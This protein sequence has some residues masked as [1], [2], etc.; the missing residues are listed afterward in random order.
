[1]EVTRIV[2]GE[3]A[4]NAYVV[5]GE[6]DGKCVLID[7]ADNADYLIAYLEEKD[8]E[9]EAIILTHGHY[10]HILAIPGLQSKWPSLEVYCHSLDVSKELYEYDM[11]RKYP[12]LQVIE[13]KKFVED[14]DSLSFIGIDFKV[15]HTPGHSPGSI[16]LQTKEGIFTGDTLFKASIGRTDFEGGN[17]SDML[18][19]L[20]IIKDLDV[21]D[22]TI[23]PGHNAISSLAWERENNLYLVRL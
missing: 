8:L 11:G 7:P 15:I 4:T 19:S 5:R 9:P 18:K 16:T 3:Y 23:Y 1:M 14:Q 22:A 21:D 17:I 6:Y 12:T 10:D 13:N 2:L 20:K